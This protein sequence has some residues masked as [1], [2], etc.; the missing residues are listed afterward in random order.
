M[1]RSMSL[2]CTFSLALTG[3]RLT[4]PSA[5]SLPCLP[6][7]VSSLSKKGEP[8]RLSNFCRSRFSGPSS[9]ATAG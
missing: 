5:V 4:S 3:A 1:R 6:T 2:V 7:P 8:L 9:S